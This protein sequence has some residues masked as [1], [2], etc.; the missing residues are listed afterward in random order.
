MAER[1]LP[2][3]EAARILGVPTESLRRAADCHG[4]TIRI[5]RA[6]RLHPKDLEELIELCRVPRRSPSLPAQ[7]HRPMG[8]HRRHEAAPNGHDRPPRG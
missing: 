6:V 5:G 7:R 4:K 2:I 8:H 3:P 1:L